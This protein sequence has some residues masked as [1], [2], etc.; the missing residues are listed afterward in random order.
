MPSLETHAAVELFVDRARAIDA[1]FDLSDESAPF[2]TEICR[3]LDGIPLA[4]E[5][6]AARIKLLSPRSSRKNSMNDFAC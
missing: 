4:I 6:A 2:V 5:L 3:R 1:H